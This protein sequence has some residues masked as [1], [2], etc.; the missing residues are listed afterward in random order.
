MKEKEEKRNKEEKRK[1]E[2]GVMFGKKCERPM[3][4]WHVESTE[5]RP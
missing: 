3:G 4:A 2:E 1:V 5:I